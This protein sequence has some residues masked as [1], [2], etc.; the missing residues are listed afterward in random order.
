MVG[1]GDSG[2]FRIRL[3]VTGTGTLAG[4]GTSPMSP[5]GGNASR[6]PDNARPRPSRPRA[7]WVR[8]GGASR[9]MGS[10]LPAG[11]NGGRG[12][13]RLLASANFGILTKGPQ[14]L[15]TGALLSRSVPGNCQCGA[16]FDKAALGISDESAVLAHHPSDVAMQVCSCPSAKSARACERASR[17]CACW[18]VRVPLGDMRCHVVP[19]RCASVRST[20]FSLCVV[21]AY[22]RDHV[23][24][25]TQAINFLK[26]APC[27]QSVNR[28]RVQTCGLLVL[29]PPAIQRPRV[30]GQGLLQGPPQRGSVE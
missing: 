14:A 2:R 7:G 26:A 28:Y 18:C 19:S 1:I 5:P 16:E 9:L 12:S 6:R 3:R 24:G 21:N 15:G 13:R 27:A 23:S 4:H 22:H 11:A 25:S 8:T 10:S 29:A 17:N 20:A 30:G